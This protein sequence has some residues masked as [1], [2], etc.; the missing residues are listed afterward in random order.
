MI[1]EIREIK[2]NILRNYIK[3]SKKKYREI[4]N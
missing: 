3:K 1:Y 4:K 2:Y